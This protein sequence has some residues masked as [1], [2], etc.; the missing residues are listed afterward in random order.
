MKILSCKDMGI[1]DGFSAKGE[2]E[3]EVIDIMIEHVKTDHPEKLEEMS[4]K[5]L[6]KM[7]R[8]KVKDEM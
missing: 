2:T 5:E 8:E 1:D 4:E 3:A 6:R 7:L